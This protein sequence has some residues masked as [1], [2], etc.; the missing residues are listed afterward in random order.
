MGN[1][2]GTPDLTTALVLVA[3]SVA[4]LLGLLSYHNRRT[5]YISW[6]VGFMVLAASFA[7]L[8]HAFGQPGFG[9]ALVV[10]LLLLA[11]MLALMTYSSRRSGWFAW[12]IGVVVF[13]LGLPFLG[14]GRGDLA[15]LSF[16]AGPGI[17][18][19]VASLHP[20]IPARLARLGALDAGPTVTRQEMA[21]ERRRWTRLAAT[22]T[23][24]SLAGVWLLGG[25]PS[26]PVAEAKVPLTF[27]A[28]KAEQGAQLFQGYGCVACHSVTGAAGAGPTLKG[29]YGSKVRLDNGTVVTADEAYVRESILQPDAKTVNGF[30]KGVMVGAIGPR[31]NEIG[32][33]QNLGA[34]V[35]Y[36][37]SVAK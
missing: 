13:L 19:L 21:Y 1:V 15:L 12:W 29:V 25:V 2:S 33:A 31:L 36:V 17:L 26:G 27:D 30:S 32:Q 28:A 5:S 23:V 4:L 10:M 18:M 11:I 34:L 14:A 9:L 7:L 37:K 16:V 35:E 20:W 3:L 22:I 24:A 6:G 8:V